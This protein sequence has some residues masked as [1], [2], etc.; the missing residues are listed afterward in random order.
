MWLVLTVI[1]AVLTYASV[2]YLNS[3]VPAFIFLALAIIFL[4]AT[5]RTRKGR[6]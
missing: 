4:A 2:L 6:R 1:C 3:M 5:W